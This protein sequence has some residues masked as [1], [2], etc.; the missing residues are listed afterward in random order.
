VEAEED[1]VKSTDKVCINK[2]N[3][4]DNVCTG[5]KRTMEEIFEKGSTKD[6]QDIVWPELKFPPINLLNV[7]PTKEMCAIHAEQQ[8]P[9]LWED[10]DEF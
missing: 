1:Y 5:C 9:T 6:T 8:D 3:L 4:V 7:W 10:Y 2:C